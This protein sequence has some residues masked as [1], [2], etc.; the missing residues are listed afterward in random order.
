MQVGA[1]TE[2]ICRARWYNTSLKRYNLIQL[3]HLSAVE[4]TVDHLE[5]QQ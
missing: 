5:E 2:V 3:L 4:Q 1:E